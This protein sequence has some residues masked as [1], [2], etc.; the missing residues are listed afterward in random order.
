M[1]F[2]LAKHDEESKKETEIH[3]SF[4]NTFILKYNL[5][6]HNFCL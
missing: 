1:Y 3:D 4:S 5:W 2:L 6:R